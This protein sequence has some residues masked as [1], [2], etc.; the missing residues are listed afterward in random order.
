MVWYNVV[1]MKS[2]PETG[3]EQAGECPDFFHPQ[4]AGE[5]YPLKEAKEV[6]PKRRS[7]HPAKTCAA[8]CPDQLRFRSA[9]AST[10]P[11]TPTVQRNG[12]TVYSLGLFQKETELEGRGELLKVLKKRGS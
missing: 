6:C 3:R 2:D 9:S 1:V 11:P 7:S 4:K 5:V 8:I 12:Q 10:K